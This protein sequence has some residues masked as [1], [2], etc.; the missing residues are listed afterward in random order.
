MAVTEN[1]VIRPRK[2]S[3]EETLLNWRAHVFIFFIA[4]VLIVSRRPDAVFHAQFFGEDGSIWYPQAYTLGWFRALFHSQDGY[5]QTL[6]RLGAAL[7]L[8]VPFRFAPLLENLIAICLQALPVNILLSERCVGFGSL[9]LRAALAA[10]YIAL[11]NSFEVDASMEEAQWHVA[12]IACLILFA[13]EPRKLAWRVFDIFAVL[14]FGLSGPFVV[15]LLPL[16]AIF[17][18]F[19]RQTWTIVLSTVLVLCAAAQMSALLNMSSSGRVK[20]FLTPTVELFF[21]ILGG[22]VYLGALLG[23]FGFAGPSLPVLILVTIVATALIAYCF[24]KAPLGWKLLLAFCVFAF[25]AALKYPMVPAPQWPTLARSPASRYWFLPTLAFAWVLVWGTMASRERFVRAISVVGVV[26]MCYGILRDWQYPEFPDLGFRNYAR[27]FRVAPAGA[28]LSIP[29]LPNG[30]WRMY[31]TKHAPRCKT[32]PTGGIDQPTAE[33]TV[34]KSVS[35]S[36]WVVQDRKLKQLSIY[37]DRKHP[38]SIAIPLATTAAY[39]QKWTA[40]LDLSDETP[41]QHEVEVRASCAG[42]C[43]AD[44][45]T[46]LIDVVR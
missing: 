28:M 35:L 24:S 13:S 40:T 32:L 37:I 8:L 44:I 26:V 27:W 22:H 41:G 42:G 30:D 29:I 6:P 20:M 12:L 46:R 7:A 18:Y 3:V 4:V 14:I 31:I 38:Q 19:R 2:L 43:E 33:S 16:A 39:T 25:A 9:G 34:S 10:V 21:K 15:M 36:G 45:A 23:A 5:F 1:P 11:P 17:W